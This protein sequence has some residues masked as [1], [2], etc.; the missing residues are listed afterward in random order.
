[1][2][3]CVLRVRPHPCFACAG[4]RCGGG[5]HAGRGAPTRLCLLRSPAIGHARKRLPYS[6]QPACWLHTRSSFF[7]LPPVAAARACH[8]HCTCNLCCWGGAGQSQTG[9]PPPL[10][11]SAHAAG[12]VCQGHVQLLHGPRLRLR[13]PPLRRAAALRHQVQV[14]EGFREKQGTQSGQ[15]SWEQREAPC[16]SWGPADTLPCPDARTEGLV[17]HC[18]APCPTLPARRPHTHP[19]SSAPSLPAPQQGPAS[20]S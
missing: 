16:C 9:A 5:R 12:P 18:T 8:P 13:P 15:D 10:L 2:V 19:P 17:P 20:D 3:G 4:E 6:P 1:M 14:G 11:A 7:T